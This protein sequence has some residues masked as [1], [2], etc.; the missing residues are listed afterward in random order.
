MSIK[1]DRPFCLAADV[2]NYLSFLFSP[3]NFQ[4]R[5]TVVTTFPHMFDCDP[6]L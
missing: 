5:L 6:E 1:S 2:Y 4:G 3:P